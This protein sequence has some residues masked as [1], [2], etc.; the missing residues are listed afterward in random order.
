M[1]IELYDCQLILV[2]SSRLAILVKE[3]ETSTP[4]WLPKAVVDYERTGKLS[5]VH[6][7]IDATMPTKVAKEKGLV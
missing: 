4:F 6:P 1:K 2:G 7:I 3:H 5:G